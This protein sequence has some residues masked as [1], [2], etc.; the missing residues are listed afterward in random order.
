MTKQE[1]I[2]E[3]SNRTY[4]ALKPSS[5][6][7]IGVF[8][9]KDIPKG[10]VPF[11]PGDDDWLDLGEE[12][13]KK[14]PLEIQQMAKFYFTKEDGQYHF[15]A[16]GCKLWDMVNF[17]NHSDQPNILGGEFRALRDIKKGEEL[18]ISYNTVDEAGFEGEQIYTLP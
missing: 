11:L 5:V 18:T 6:Q 12:D 10:V 8:A 14:L 17:L 13:M 7:G 3:L 15:P 4:C 1:L 16:Y 2:D 9:I